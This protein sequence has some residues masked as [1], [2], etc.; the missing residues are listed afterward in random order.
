MADLVTFTCP[1]HT[2]GKVRRWTIRGRGIAD[3]LELRSGVVMVNRYRVVAAGHHQVINA[4]LNRKPHVEVIPS[5]E[6]IAAATGWMK[7]QSEQALEL[8]ALRPP[9]P[10]EQLIVRRRES[11]H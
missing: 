9:S 11:D 7:E 5:T 3:V 4:M 6:Q 10:L 2:T 8:A 1:D